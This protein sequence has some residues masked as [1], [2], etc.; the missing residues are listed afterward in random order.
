M[1]KLNQSTMILSYDQIINKM[2]HSG[3]TNKQID[4]LM[5]EGKIKFKAFVKNEDMLA[6]MVAKSVGIDVDSIKNE[7]TISKVDKKT[8]WKKYLDYQRIKMKEEGT[9][10]DNFI[11]KWIKLM[12]KDKRLKNLVV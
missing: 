7:I 2:I 11:D 4:N 3:F 9:V 6:V 5:K 12:S 8:K 10:S 1:N